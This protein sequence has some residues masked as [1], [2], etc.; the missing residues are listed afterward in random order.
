M[1][2]VKNLSKSIMVMAIVAF[3]ISLT[4]CKKDQTKQDQ[5]QEEDVIL[6]EKVAGT[7]NGYTL[8]SCNYFKDNFTADETLSITKV[9]NEKV[10]ITFASGTWGD[11]SISNATVTQSGNTY[12]ISGEGKT[13]MGHGGQTNEYACSIAATINTTDNATITFNIPAVMGGTSV[14]FKTGKASTGYYV[15]DKYKGHLTM[16]VSGQEQGNCDTSIVLSAQ[17]NNQVSITLPEI[18]SGNMSIPETTIENIV[19]STTDYKVFTINE[20]EISFTNPT[21]GTKYTGTLS[22]SISESGLQLNYSLKPGAMPMSIVF[23]FTP[24]Q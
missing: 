23:T 19:V 21:S 8:A 9:D 1:K 13:S 10:N 18:G 5:K 11:F 4:S 7:Y 15:A 16:S 24:L 22:G 2:T 12:S 14:V 3:A 6:S 17:E 20:Q